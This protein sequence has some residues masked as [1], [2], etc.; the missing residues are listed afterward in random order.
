VGDRSF[1]YELIRRQS[2]TVDFSDEQTYTACFLFHEVII[3][4]TS[5]IY[6]DIFIERCLL[7]ANVYYSMFLLEKKDNNQG[8]IIRIDLVSMES[9]YLTKRVLV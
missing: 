7:L 6:I 2:E 4:T 9:I 1:F 5:Y 8:K 3:K